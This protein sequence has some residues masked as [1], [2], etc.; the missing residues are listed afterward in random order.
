H[1]FGEF[2]DESTRELSR[3]KKR[4]TV[5]GRLEYWTKCT[6][7]GRKLLWAVVGVLFALGFVIGGVRHVWFLLH[8]GEQR[9]NIHASPRRF[10][11]PIIHSPGACPIT[12]EIGLYE[13]DGRANLYQST[14]FK[15]HLNSDRSPPAR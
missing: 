10:N 5:L 14:Y 13:P 9:A 12:A 15:C 8:F 11:R 3:M 4:T 6:R 1:K 7:Q 2:T